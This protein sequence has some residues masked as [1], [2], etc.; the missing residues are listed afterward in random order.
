MSSMFD[1]VVVGAGP[2]GIASAAIAAEAGLRV[3]LIDDNRGPGGQIWRG[4][5]PQ[6]NTKR[7]H[8]REFID[9]NERLGG[10][11]CTMWA[12]TQVID[13]LAPNTLRVERD[14]ES[15]DVSYRK[16]IIATGARERFLPFPGWT[17]PG[18]TGAGGLQALVKSGLEVAEKR[19]V[20]AGTGPL[21]L[22]I[23]AGLRDAGA[24]VLAIYEQSPTSRLINLSLTLLS[25]PGK[26]VEGI[27]YALT[28]RGIPY[29]TGC[30]V[31]S[32]EGSTHLTQV[33]VTNGRTRW[34]HDCDYLASGFHLVPNLELPL[35]LGCAISDGYVKTSE[36][37]QSSVPDV[38][39]VGEVTGIGGLDKALLEGEI[40]GWFAAGRE[41]KARELSRRLRKFQD[42]AHRLDQSFALRSELRNLCQPETIVCRCEDI[43]FSSLQRCTS[44]RE[45]K[46]HTRC[47]MG[48]CQGRI[49]G[50]Q[51]EFLF[52]W[53]SVSVRPPIY[54]AS[55][56]SV[57]GRP[58]T[59][60]GASET[61]EHV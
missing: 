13:Y 54:P 41:N 8:A 46:L 11:T 55:V 37:Q 18:V 9:W 17:L 36:F 25:H 19:V 57:A 24:K 42:F 7:P 32:A 6:S 28:L 58:D 34:T 10:T 1:V 49:C 61:L 50:P 23:A 56:S 21:L 4:M 16:L 60:R 43:A 29:R 44:W 31:T 2:G 30:W 5:R 15:C 14:G 38:A 48:A 47:G 27:G 51:T 26:I 35:L 39:C 45:A 52:D 33:T 3:C 53:R 59:A 20:V 12:D 40:A 22:A